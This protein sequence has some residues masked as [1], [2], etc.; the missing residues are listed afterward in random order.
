VGDDDGGVHDPSEPFKDTDRMP[1]GAERILQEFDPV[2]QRFL[3]NKIVNSW[4]YHCTLV[5]MFDED[6]VRE[7]DSLEFRPWRDVLMVPFVDRAGVTIAKTEISGEK[8]VVAT[9][10]IAKDELV[11]AYP[12]CMVGSINSILREYASQEDAFLRTGWP[13]RPNDVVDLSDAPARL[14]MD[15]AFDIARTI[16]TQPALAI[17][18]NRCSSNPDTIYNAHIIRQ[19]LE[20]DKP[21]VKRIVVNNSSAACLHIFIVAERDIAV[22]E[23]VLAIPDELTTKS[24]N[25]LLREKAILDN[26]PLQR[27]LALTNMKTVL[28]L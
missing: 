11:A 17:S 7:L 6:N 25:S 5:S 18:G 12:V 3:G 2:V 15:Y 13:H 9:Q 26:A 20:N 27:T 4:R 16:H 21:N 22:G 24:I 19:P 23:E 14:L 28:H 10:N 8:K 1:A